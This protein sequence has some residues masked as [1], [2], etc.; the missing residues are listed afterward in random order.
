MANEKILIVDDDPTTLAMLTTSVGKAGYQVI[1]AES[2]EGAL[3]MALEHKPDLVVLDL[4]LPDTS[5]LEICRQLLEEPETQGMLIIMV[6]A[7]G[8]QSDKIYGLEVGADDYLVKPVDV[9]ELLARIRALFRRH[10]LR[11]EQEA[12]MAAHMATPSMDL[13]GFS[14]KPEQLSVGKGGKSTQLTALE[15]K[16]LY[17]LASNPDETYDRAKIQ[18][19]VWGA[20]QRNTERAVDVLVNRL[21]SK[22]EQLPGGDK[23][24][25]TVR[26]IGY[27]FRP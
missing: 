21:R 23:I 2:G 27:R 11:G 15:F 17:H 4:L 26:G 5:G 6:T 12:A 22:L 9:P 8:E 13:D 16:L 25:K 18:E 3:R 24:V 7:L 1:S 10:Q 20:N 14:V 19:M